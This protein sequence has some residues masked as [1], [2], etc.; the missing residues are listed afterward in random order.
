MMAAAVVTRRP[1]GQSDDAIV[2]RLA[3]ALGI[4]NESEVSTG[5]LQLLKRVATSDTR[6]VNFGA[7]VPREARI[8][9]DC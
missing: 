4:R 9:R 8:Y 2:A 6:L 5:R 7:R 1:H 3:K